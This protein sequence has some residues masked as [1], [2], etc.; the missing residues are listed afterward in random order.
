MPSKVKQARYLRQRKPRQERYLTS[1]IHQ[2]FI[3]S[4]LVFCSACT[5]ISNLRKYNFVGY[6]LPFPL[7]IQ[8]KL[9]IYFFIFRHSPTYL[10]V[11]KRI[12][13]QRTTTVQAQLKDVSNLFLK[14]Q[15]SLFL[16]KIHQHYS[17]VGGRWKRSIIKTFEEVIGIIIGRFFVIVTETVI[18]FQTDLLG[19]YG[20]SSHNGS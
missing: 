12:P 20:R 6:Q 17:G 10:I 2:S 15:T 1:L 16:P 9:P 19:M 13:N 11:Q 18:V 7:I 8:Y 5:Q 3:Y 4:E 14:S